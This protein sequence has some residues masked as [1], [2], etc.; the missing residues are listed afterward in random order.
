MVRWC[1][2]SL[3][4]NGGRPERRSIMNDPVS[5]SAKL[6]AGPPVAFTPEEEQI[7]REAVR[8]AMAV[9][10]E[11]E[12][13]EITDLALVFDDLG[14]DS[15]DVFDLM[16]QLS[17]EFQAPFEPEHLPEEMIFGGEGVTFGEFCQGMVDFLKHPP[18]EPLSQASPKT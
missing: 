12:P 11:C 8:K 5:L 13:E 1:L 17:E 7:F 15:I 6:A 2:L 14:L 9:T 10:L 18:T 16:D 3:P 4:P